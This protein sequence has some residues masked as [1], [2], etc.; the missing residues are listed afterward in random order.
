[1]FDFKLNKIELEQYITS[2]LI[3]SKDINLDIVINIITINTDEIYYT[4]HSHDAELLYFGLPLW[5]LSC[6]ALLISTILYNS[7]DYLHHIMVNKLMQS[8]EIV[9]YVR[10]K[11]MHINQLDSP[12]FNFSINEFGIILET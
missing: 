8:C 5:V 1:V 10:R 9:F 4:N 11:K 7:F 3:A 2:K 6:G 12:G